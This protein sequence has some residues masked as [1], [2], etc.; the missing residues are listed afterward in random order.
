LILLFIFLMTVAMVSVGAAWFLYRA[1]HTV[2]RDATVKGRVHRIGA[3]IDGQVKSME[4][5]PGQRVA[6]GDTLFHLEDEHLQAAL[7]TAMAELNVVSNRYAAERLNVEYERRRLPLELERCESA[8]RAATGEVE[9]AASHQDQLQREFER[10]RS[11]VKAEI[12]STSELDRLQSERDNAR[13]LLKAARGKRAAS[14]SACRLA[15]V[16]LDGV[17]VREAELEVPAAEVERAQERVSSVKA[18]LA[19][20]VIRAPE[21]GWVAER[22]VEPGG[23]ARVGDPILSLW[24]GAP[25]IEAWADEKH[26]SRITIGSP[27]DVTLTA[28]AGRKLQGRV[29][30]I[31]VLADKEL[32]P[33]PVPSTLHSLFPENARVPIRVAIPTADL[34][35]QPGLTALVGIQDTDPEPWTQL[36]GQIDRFLASIPAL[37]SNIHTQQIDQEGNP[38]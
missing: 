9:A 29:E 20:T 2:I 28:F 34:R 32:Q 27:V 16:Q 15:Q 10:V 17:R 37:L 8:R 11:L 7:R 38:Q 19:A 24:I 13:A 14:E 30:A 4:V 33:T 35:L 6:K 31:G 21:D 1:G 23:S 18:D 3:R 12:S 26:L 5:Q 36:A 25:W 22:I